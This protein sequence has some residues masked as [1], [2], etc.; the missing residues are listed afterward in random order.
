MKIL[1][2]GIVAFAVVWTLLWFHAQKPDDPIDAILASGIGT[3]FAGI[4]LGMVIDAEH[5]SWRRVGLFFTFIGDASL[6]LSV[7]YDRLF[8]WEGRETGIDTARAALI[9][10]GVILAGIMVP[11]WKSKVDREPAERM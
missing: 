8:G 11:Y 7:A 3:V 2:L 1:G 9:V 4:V 6:Y 5:W 10:G